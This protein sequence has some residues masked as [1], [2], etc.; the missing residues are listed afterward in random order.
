[1]S[2]IN[3]HSIDDI[4]SWLKEPNNLYI[5]R[6]TNKLKGSKWRN[7]YKLSIFKS[8]IKVVTLFERYV[9]HNK[10]LIQDLGELKGKTLGCWCAPLLCHG[11]IL[12]QL[13]EI[14]WV[15]Q[16]TLNNL[17]PAFPAFGPPKVLVFEATLQEMSS[18]NTRKLI[19]TNLEANIT[20]QQLRSFFALYQDDQV[21]EHSSVEI[22]QNTN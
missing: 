1:M 20:V 16:S 17:F 22:S 12:L 4:D 10:N 7:R 21:K 13:A 11:Q 5:G 3:L 8:R 18:P 14:Y 15:G 2:I 19:V 9:R 6:S